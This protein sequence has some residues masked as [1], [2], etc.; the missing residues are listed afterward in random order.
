MVLRNEATGRV[1]QKKNTLMKSRIQSHLDFNP[2]SEERMLS[3][4]DSE[5]TGWKLGG[6]Q[7]AR[8]RLLM[9]RIDDDG[10]YIFIG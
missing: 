3:H 10:G 7:R 5:V 6:S 4:R 9:N 1:Q 8:Q 2:I